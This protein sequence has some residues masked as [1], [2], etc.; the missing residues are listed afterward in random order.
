MHK[1][2]GDLN[3]ILCVC[4]WKCICPTPSCALQPGYL[5]YHPKSSKYAFR[6]G[7]RRDMYSPLESS[8]K[9]SLQP[10]VS[11]LQ[12]ISIRIIRLIYYRP[13][14]TCSKVMFLQA[15]V[16]LVKGSVWETPPWADP[17][18]ACSLARHPPGQTP[19]GR[20]LSR[21]T[22]PGRSLPRKTPPTDTPP[23]PSRRL[24]QRTVLILLE[25]ILVI[26]SS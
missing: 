2:K 10:R 14:R 8:S 23:L 5:S 13:Q 24:L 19:P 6:N 15:S 3:V 16:I 1:L 18:G 7:V 12:S 11:I 22:P 20:D 25:C 26:L 9:L 4:P 17:P 21:Q